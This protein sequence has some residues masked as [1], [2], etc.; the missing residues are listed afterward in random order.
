M[1]AI[2]N[3]PLYSLS[4]KLNLLTL[5]SIIVLS[6]TI[7]LLNIKIIN[8]IIVKTTKSVMFPYYFK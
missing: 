1:F 7:V 2:I 5:K 4:D 3:T 8:Y 6:F